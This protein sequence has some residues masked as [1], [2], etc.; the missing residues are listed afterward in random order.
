MFFRITSLLIASIA[1]S[2][3]ASAQTSD[4]T[5]GCPNRGVK[6]VDAQHQGSDQGESCGH[7]VGFSFG[8]VTYTPSDDQCPSAVT[9]IPPH[10]VQD[11]QTFKPC[12]DWTAANQFEITKTRYSCTGIGCGLFWLEGCCEPGDSE[13]VMIGTSY[14]EFRCRPCNDD[15]PVP[16]PSAD[17][18]SER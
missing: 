8:G 5:G 14:V 3:F 4:A 16:L 17:S 2:S 15:E 10:W 6:Q 9:Y 11:P 12:T 1:L 13:V 18:S 7:G